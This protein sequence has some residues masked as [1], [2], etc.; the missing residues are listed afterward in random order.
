[1]ATLYR[2]TAR[3]A[4]RHAFADGLM[5]TDRSIGGPWFDAWLLWGQPA[6]AFL[7]TWGLLTLA[8]QLPTAQADAVA[9]AF[10]AFVAILT[11][12]HLIAVAPRA[13]LNRDVFGRFPRRFVV[14]P[15]LLLASFALSPA[16]LV[17]GMVLAVFWD[18]HHSAMQ[19]FGLGRIYDLKAG[20]DP[21]VL[22]RVDMLLNAALYIGPIV[23]GASMIEHVRAFE[24]F[25]TIE[26]TVFTRAPALVEGWSGSVR[27][28]GVAAWLIVVGI[29]ALC[30][31]RASR[32]GYRFSAHKKA[33]L[34]VT[35]TVS[36]AA[37]GLASPLVAFA[38]INLF[39]AVQY[40]ALVWLKEG[41]RITALTDRRP[42]LRRAALPLF[43]LACF[44]FG[45]AYWLAMGAGAASASWFLAP[46]VTCSLLHF[47][48]DGF[49]W[50]VRAKQV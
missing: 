32:A 47:W 22:R 26:W 5:R 48:Y 40:F 17:I 8:G 42:R 38:A 19:T 13:Y 9:G 44:A 20:N 15:L 21:L 2:E 36:I 4:A 39:H 1:M 34:A 10:L 14:V 33:L 7:L 27:A 16:L 3:P 23:A 18:V 45:A 49:V 12:A 35:A 24:S 28:A 31:V 43:V 30:Y 37:W 50:S 41:K 25:A 6:I 29:A 11:Y 46:F